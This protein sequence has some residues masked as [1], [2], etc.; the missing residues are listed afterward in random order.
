MILGRLFTVIFLFTFIFN[1]KAQNFSL[2]WTRL[3]EG[4][5]RIEEV[6]AQIRL[7]IPK[8]VTLHDNV[9][10]TN[11]QWLDFVKQQNRQWTDRLYELQ[12]EY[13]NSLDDY[14]VKVNEKKKLES[15]KILLE[16]EI[17]NLNLSID[18]YKNRK[19]ILEE[20]KRG[21]T[22]IYTSKLNDIPTS[23]VLLSRI[24][25]ADKEVV[26]SSNRVVAEFLPQRQK[27]LFA[28]KMKENIAEKNQTKMDNIYRDNIVIT[29]R[30]TAGRV[31][32]AE[33]YYSDL[34]ASTNNKPYYMRICR[35]EIFPAING[36]TSHESNNNLE[37]YE[38]KFLNTF[39]AFDYDAGT[40][41]LSTELNKTFNI[42]EIFG[43]NADEVHT[44][45]QKLMAESQETNNSYTLQRKNIR[46]DYKKQKSILESEIKNINDSEILNLQRKKSKKEGKLIAVK[47]DLG[48][49]DDA[50]SLL[51][52]N[53]NE[54]ENEYTT[55]YHTRTG[56]RNKLII[57]Q[58]TTYYSGH[59]SQFQDMGKE[60][61]DIIQ[62]IETT[63]INTVIYVVTRK[64]TKYT[65]SSYTKKYKT[66]VDAFKIISIDKYKDNSGDLMFAL[67]IAYRTK[68]QLKD[69]GF[70]STTISKGKNNKHTDPE[71]IFVKGDSCKMGSETGEDDE[72]PVHTVYLDD[73]YMS[74]YEI[75][76]EEYCKFLNSYGSDKVK[77]G[78]YKGQTMI[79]EYKWGVKKTASQ[80]KPQTGYERHPVV[81]V[82]WYGAN[83]YCKWRGGRLPTEAEWE[84]AARGGVKTHD[85]ASQL[86]AGSNKIDD[87]AWYSGN[88]D[89]KTHQ[90]G[91][92]K[93]NELG[94]YDMSGNVWEWCFD[95]YNKNYYK[96]S[97]GVK[98]PICNSGNNLRV[99][100]G[101]SWYDLDN[102]C[103]V[104]VRG[105]Y[106]PDV[107]NYDLGFRF[108]RPAH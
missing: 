52:N 88:S 37:T 87:V 12:D 102:Y 27:Q 60:T 22:D 18:V 46:K 83:E 67:N 9:K 84:Y 36:N 77:N 7:K 20:K 35:Y 76:N 13:F 21:L 49:I 82:T 56:Y 69:K 64:E 43:E 89:S 41:I 81:N 40:R 5:D 108:V 38:K 65:F 44:Y 10:K 55:F 85:R 42:N 51:E 70:G 32:E 103:R 72:K 54:A 19:E 47:S 97:E 28:D 25:I 105:R 79:Y 14:Y 2:D 94:L 4:N 53:L 16:N 61:E 99:L 101:G 48:E 91:Q 23:A 11:D 95:W 45:L 78:E 50:I 75:T 15:E 24:E 33:T 100:R 26:N 98:N 66:E 63:E 104:A 107:G 57:E 90:V 62:N 58:A 86:Y 80:W 1:I 31:Y 93:K 39:E 30:V 29:R 3:P 8:N 73:F 106:G 59:K 34:L 68:S 92:K 71:L 17:T 74:R 6:K 96:S